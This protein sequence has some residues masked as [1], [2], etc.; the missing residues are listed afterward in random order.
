M[1][2]NTRTSVKEPRVNCRVT[3]DIQRR[4]ER[5]AET[6]GIDASDVVRMAINR[7]LPQFEAEQQIELVRAPKE[8]TAA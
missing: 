8:G 3:A 2:T 1:A 5:V 7:V 4:I 6:N